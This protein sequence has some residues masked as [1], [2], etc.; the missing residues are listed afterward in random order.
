M[1]LGI[2]NKRGPTWRRPT[3]GGIQERD[4]AQSYRNLSKSVRLEWPRTS[5]IL[6][7]LLQRALSIRVKNQ[8]MM[9]TGASGEALYVNIERS[10]TQESDARPAVP[11]YKLAQLY[12]LAAK[13][14]E[15]Q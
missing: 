13:S 1:F 11:S 7:R 5:A 15:N 9:Q 2:V 14:E 4:L 3:D 8:T 12:Q 10:K 6:E